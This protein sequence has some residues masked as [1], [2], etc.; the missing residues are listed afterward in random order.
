MRPHKI[1]MKN[2]REMVFATDTSTTWYMKSFIN[3]E[4]ASGLYH[5][6][7]D[8]IEW[9]HDEAVIYGKKIVTKRKIAWFADEGFDYNYS[10]TSRIAKAWDIEL[11]KI[12][13]KLEQ[14][15]GAIFNSCLLN[16]YHDG[17]E[18]MAWHSDD[19]NHLIPNSPVAI[20]SLGAER[21][22]KLR[23]TKQKTKQ[24][25][26]VL[27]QGSLIVMEGQTQKYWQHEIPKMARITI[28]RI[29]MTWRSMA[30]K[31]IKKSIKTQIAYH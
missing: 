20:V 10:G 14:E 28:P 30:D 23:E 3:V 19:Q 25:K 15:T 16:L 27:L 4:S 31:K 29:S 5:Y 18:G 2:R 24:Y 1:L 13:K 12:K 22:F 21:Y 17:K 26:I 11:I 9:A 6:L 7:L 8:N